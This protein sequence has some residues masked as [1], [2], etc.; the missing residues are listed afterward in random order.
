MIAGDAWIFPDNPCR[1]EVIL[2]YGSVQYF[3]AFG[4]Q[5]FRLSREELDWKMSEL[6]QRTEDA[7]HAKAIHA[8]WKEG[9]IKGPDDMVYVANM[10]IPYGF[11]QKHGFGSTALHEIIHKTKVMGRT[12][13]AA[14][15]AT[16]AGLSFMRKHGFEEVCSG[17][18][19]KEA[20]C[21]CTP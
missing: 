3:L 14:A 2:N 11:M 1:V 15:P 6:E 5:A 9:K 21:A 18:W 12:Y 4:E 13:V 17:L 16:P 8:M 19:L 20:S 7:Q 10:E